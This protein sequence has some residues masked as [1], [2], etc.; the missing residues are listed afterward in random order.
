MRNILVPIG[1]TENAVKTL[2]YAIDFAEFM[3]SNVYVMQAFTLITKAGG[4][5]NVEKAVV[6]ST[7]NQLDEIVSQVDK[8]DVSVTIAAYNGDVVDGVKA[9]NKQ[10]GI[11]LIILEPKTTDIREEVFLGNTSGSII[12]QTN[13][14][15]LI[16]PEGNSFYDYKNGLVAF[17]SGIVN[18]ESILDALIQFKNAFKLYLNLL[19]V[20]TPK[21][22]AEDLVLN[23][24]LESLSDSLKT[25]E[26]TS[27]F[28]GVLEHFQTNQPD[29]LIVFRRKR[30]FFTKL[31]EK[32]IILKR[33][34]RCS[35][36]LL[37]LSVKK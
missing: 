9:I 28:E 33:E 19:L 25:S 7:T 32:N 31:W 27:T 8:K 34:F 18:H 21:Y 15:T 24:I 2:Q 13:I 37:V 16:I 11:D 6:K 12:K 20:K 35:I 23:P 22:T 30:G 14:P 4:L 29:I 36:P 26:N 5:A 10:Y 17:K 1:T 3:D